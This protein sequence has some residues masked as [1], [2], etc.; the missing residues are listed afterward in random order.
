M[1]SEAGSPEVSWPSGEGWSERVGWLVSAD[2]DWSAGK[3]NSDNTTEDAVDGDTGVNSQVRKERLDVNRSRKQGD[4]SDMIGNRT[5]V[6][7]GEG[8]LEVRE[9]WKTKCE[10]LDEVKVQSSPRCAPSPLQGCGSEIELSRSGVHWVGK[11]GIRLEWHKY[12]NA[13]AR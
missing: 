13:F 7:Q 9:T 11:D 5:K 6:I 1:P 2:D 8:E 3:S 4:I 12:Q 10:G